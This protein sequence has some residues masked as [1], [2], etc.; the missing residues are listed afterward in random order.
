[1]DT[2]SRA[3]GIAVV[4][5]LRGDGWWIAAG[6]VL[7]GIAIAIVL[8]S[9]LGPVEHPLGPSFIPAPAVAEGPTPGGPIGLGDG[10]GCPQC[11]PAV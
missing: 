7:L 8:V 5:E 9:T 1:M 4:R 6:I 11:R 3:S 10:L 2:A